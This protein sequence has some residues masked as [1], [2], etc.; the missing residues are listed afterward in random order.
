MGFK[1]NK[2]KFFFILI[3]CLFIIA[4]CEDDKEKDPPVINNFNLANGNV[5]YEICTINWTVLD[6]SGIANT[7]LWINGIPIGIDSSS[8]YILSDTETNDLSII[9]SNYAY[10]WN[11]I[12]LAN[13]NY[14][15][16]FFAEDELGNSDFSETIKIQVDNSLSVPDP[17]QVISVIRNGEDVEVLWSKAN[18]SDF[19]KYN[20]KISNNDDM[21]QIISS[22]SLFSI[23]DTTKTFNGIDPTIDIHI[24]IE[25]VDLYG[26]SAFSQ[27]YTSLKDNS[28]VPVILSTIEYDTTRLI[29]EW[30][31][32][33]DD[34]FEIYMIYVSPD[35]DTDG[36][37]IL[38]ITDRSTT[39]HEIYDF[40]PNQQNWYS[41]ITLDTL[42]QSSRS[43]YQANAINLP[44][45]ISEI[46]SIEYDFDSLTIEW[47][48][49]L[50]FDFSEYVIMR[51]EN[52][53]SEFLPIEVIDNVEQTVFSV[54]DFDPTVENWFMIKTIDYWSL[55]TNS[56]S[57]SNL[58]DPL[59]VHSDVVSVAYNNDS[60]VVEWEQSNDQDFLRF[61][62]LYSENQPDDFQIIDIIYDSS[63]NHISLSS[64]NP[65]IENWF[66]IQ[67]V[68][69]WGQMV[70]GLELSNTIDAFPQVSDMV[71]VIFENDFF[72]VEWMKNREED[73]HSYSLYV[74]S[75]QNMT[76]A[77]VEHYSEVIDDT[78]YSFASAEG[79]INYFQVGVKD[80]WGQETLSEPKRGSSYLTFTRFYGGDLTDDGRDVLQ[81]GDG[82]YLIVGSSS[83]YGASG[84]DGF[85]TKKDISGDEIWFEVHGGVNPEQI[86]DVLETTDNGYL[87]LGSTESYGSSYTNIFLAKVNQDGTEEWINNYGGA[88]HDEGR[89]I[90]RGSDGN[91]YIIG[92]T[93]SFGFGESDV[94]LLIVDQ[95][96]NQISDYTYG[97]NLNNYGVDLIESFDS[98]FILL[99]YNE[100]NDSGDLNIR[101]TK[102]NSQGFDIWTS[103][104]D[105]SP[106]TDLASAIS[107][108]GLGTYLIS[109][110]VILNGQKD[111]LVIGFTE[112]GEMI[113]SEIYGGNGSDWF[114]DIIFSSDGNF[115]LS[116]TMEV[117]D[118][119]SWIL[120]ID[121]S[122]MVIWQRNLG[123]IGTDH[124]NG[125]AE[126]EDS[127]Y[128]LTGYW[129]TEGSNDYTL[130]K[131]DSEGFVT[132]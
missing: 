73:F 38:S 68:D 107:G 124:L 17:V 118:Y 91:Y 95:E 99:S 32:S 129:N 112:D 61:E 90:I 63:Q 80:I 130:I 15:I 98:G 81:T 44:P 93:T 97:D 60:L 92:S 72:N 58:L 33:D 127:G 94:W 23:D 53:F 111:G 59:P 87:I 1:N 86:W 65:T 121:A 106:A 126:A 46:L 88:G 119:D 43:N 52:Q 85:I 34:D 57:I 64:F 49:S 66:K 2:I 9:K 105:V 31:E 69:Y 102:I 51:S 76:N 14:D 4:G 116:G 50:E 27:I 84:L 67:T 100:E 20:I 25:L 40:N 56:E 101:V 48:Q 36:M 62:V 16:S 13:D 47:E 96:G 114:S 3:S 54:S 77:V 108:D 75:D 21:N 123:L 10:E 79:V 11:T 115:V 117:D 19:S 18:I 132:P 45:Y 26:F 70:R 125:I 37:E 29:I 122:G 103:L 74:A 30:T 131:T 109:G 120:K 78:T 71:A 82:Q 83:S 39:I 8:L 128:I 5:V 35:P 6:A 104:F 12:G 42:G 113:F 24:S 55:I 89:S 110:S 7:E 22:D 41:I 28:P